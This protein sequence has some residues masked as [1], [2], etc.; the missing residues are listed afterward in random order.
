MKKTINS[1][2]V[3]GAIAAGVLFSC[4]Q[5]ESQTKTEKEPVEQ[6]E[7]QDKEAF[8]W[9]ADRFADIRVLRYKINGFDKL[10]LDQ[11][12]LA[13]YLTQAGLSG[14]DIIYDQNYK[15]NL[16]IRKALDHIVANHEGEESE[17]WNKF[18]QYTKQV[19][20]ANGIHHHYSKDK[21]Q[22]LFD[23][24]YFNTLLAESNTTISEEALTAIFDPNVD[25]KAVNLDASKGIIKGS[26]NNFYGEGVTEK[27][28]DAYY[29]K[30][31]NPNDKK[32]ISYGLNS[33]MVLNDKGEIE[34]IP[35]KIGGLYGE[36]LTKV[37][38]WLDKA[39]TVSEND[40]QKYALELLVKYYKTG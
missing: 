27:M 28:V 17:N 32:P 3:V 23:K 36:A 4:S 31:K 18:L 24:A 16:E 9:E 5:N 8:E 7:K 40:A 21:F 1:R 29:K 34:E 38:Y 14:R 37:A 25:A 11:K 6:T 10:T 12:K 15:H 19:W 26:A 30:L 33:K 2:I 22:P 35:Y 13:Y 39:A 20:F